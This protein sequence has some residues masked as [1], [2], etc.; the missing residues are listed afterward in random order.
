MESACRSQAFEKRV[1]SILKESLFCLL[2]C[3]YLIDVTV[4]LDVIV[5]GVGGSHGEMGG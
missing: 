1:I 4:A 2:V 3:A 5:L